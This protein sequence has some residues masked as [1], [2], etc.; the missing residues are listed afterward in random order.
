ME[1]F[2][3]FQDFDEFLPSRLAEHPLRCTVIGQLSHLEIL[4]CRLH[5]EQEQEQQDSPPSP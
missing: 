1:N 5:K 3:E 2:Q 4:H